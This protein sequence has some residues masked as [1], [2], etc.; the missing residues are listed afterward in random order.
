MLKWGKALLIAVAALA[1]A[2]V[3][4]LGAGWLLARF[5]GWAIL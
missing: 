2:G 5:L 4:G 1:A 3:L